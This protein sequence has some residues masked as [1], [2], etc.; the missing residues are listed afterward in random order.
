MLEGKK[1]KLIEESKEQN[2]VSLLSRAVTALEE[3]KTNELKDAIGTISRAIAAI[4]IP[5]SNAQ[6]ITK[7]LT[8]LNVKV[9]IANKTHTENIVNAL[10]GMIEE[11]NSNNLKVID[12]I[13]RLEESKSLD[14]LSG[15][16]DAIANHMELN[17]K[18]EWDYEVSQR[19]G[20]LIKKAKLKRIK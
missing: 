12:H 4:E 13:Q 3:N 15:K 18:A 14:N 6:E 9:N 11:M 19:D 2:Q 7:M 1:N 10:S 5:K 20:E 17:R 16:L 8:D